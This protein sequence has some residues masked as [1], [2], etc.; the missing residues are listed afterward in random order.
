[1]V[2]NWTTQSARKSEGNEEEESWVGHF[3]FVGRVK[4]PGNK[5]L[6]GHFFFACIMYVCVRQ[7]VYIKRKIAHAALAPQGKPFPSNLRF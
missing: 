1:M 2:D 4:V 7:P 3:I 5:T 6:R